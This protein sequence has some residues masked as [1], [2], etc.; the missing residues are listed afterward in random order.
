MDM[1]HLIEK[2]DKI[3]FAGQA[4]GQKP[5]DQVRGI[6]KATK[7]KSGEH[8][9]K[10]RL[11]G[12]SESKSLLQDLEK[13]IVEGAEER[14]LKEE[15]E[16]FSEQDVEEGIGRD[17][18]KLGGIA[19]VGIG[20]GLG[21]NYV[22]QQQPRVEVGG[23]KA[24]LIQHPG[25]GR[26]PDNA[27][28]LKGKDGKTYTVWASK[29]KGSTQYYATPSDNVKE[30][31]AEDAEPVDREFALVKKLGRL[32]QRIVQNPKL[33]K[34]YS[35]AI[36]NENIDWIVGLI[37][38]GTG[39]TSAEVT[40]LADLFGE[41]GGG[42][43]RIVD[44]AWAVKEG[45]WDKD[46]MN[47]YR[48]HRS[49]GVAEG[50]KSPMFK[51][52]QRA[53]RIRSL[54]NLIAIAREKDRPLRVQ[55]LELEL[56]KLQ[57]VSEGAQQLNIQQLATISDEAL[58]KAYG[59]GRSTPG[60]SFGWQANLKSAS[61]A[62]QM[63]D[64]GITDIEVISD[65]IHKGWNVTAQAFVKNP[66]QFSD[67]E[68]LKASGKLEAKLQQRAQLMKQNY[69]QLPEDEKE[70]DRV[71][72]RALLQA[73]KGQ[74]G[75]AEGL[76]DT[77]KKIEDTILKLE[78][79]LKFAKTP[80]QW[81]NIKNRIE[82]LQAG[83]NRSKQGVAEMDSQGHTGSRDRKK[84]SKYGSRDHYDLGGPES[85]G[86]PLTAK[87]MMDKAHKAMM[88]SM[89]NAEK[90]DKGWRNPNIDEGAGNIGNAIKSLYQKIYRA[91]DDEIEYF[92][93]DSPIFAQ[94]WDEY[95]GDL[96]SII[97][98][99][100][101]SELEVIKAELESYVDDANLTEAGVYNPPPGE[102][103]A[104]DSH[105][106]SP[107]GSVETNTER[108]PT[109]TVT[110]DIPLMIRLLE[111]A[112]E[113]AKD[114]MDLHTV[115]EKMI[116]L[117]KKGS[118]TMSDYDSIVKPAEI[119][120]DS[121]GSELGYKKLHP[122]AFQARQKYPLAKSDLEA[123]VMWIADRDGAEL[124][125][126]DQENDRE[127]AEIDQLDREE[128]GI[129]RKLKMLSAQIADLKSA[130]H[131]RAVKEAEAVATAG[132]PAGTATPGQP[133]DP[134]AQAQLKQQQSKLQQ[135]IANLKTAGVQ[136]DPAKAAQTLQKTDTGAPMTA[137]DKDTIA[138]M[139][140]ALG[141]VLANPSTATQL[142][143]LIKKAGG[144]V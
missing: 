135:N 40:K 132:A 49:Q 22:D 94:Y 106:P 77:Q 53:D 136:I 27:M 31:V 100:D 141:N 50:E 93:N 25:W 1:K 82:R 51:D 36:D 19:A 84:T 8:P 39:A 138:A 115:A 63:I 83:L 92:Y 78:Q 111:Y 74:Q 87:Q 95:E 70:K 6:E 139:A 97:A 99:V 86:R 30:G 89:S 15:F 128:D 71:V 35:E 9:F 120:E 5:G 122:I 112:R 38:D 18:A 28:T 67:T 10:G 133:A 56:K 104:T 58:D 131:S 60:N 119:S 7:K 137:T 107:I 26:V 109:D 11:V 20:A 12:A 42:L 68:K 88:K 16:N 143:T 52:A 96:D 144:G 13:Q 103:S 116:A 32:G 101:P 29:G 130:L 75:V 57:G 134:A 17:M 76:S 113:D 43:G 127:D 105:S 126:L 4:V 102:A 114:D 61:Y 44:F 33:W 117:G 3:E 45:T 72:A 142:N 37:Q 73:I 140:P 129:Q 64:K 121:E 48:D 14:R 98:E 90:V 125:R 23:Q 108:N 85:T 69:A 118:L 81:D 55:E 54:K 123:L 62:K 66:D 59:Y 65:A 47:P 124:S 80:E 21:A 24:Y 79:R 46:F 110:L 34:K 41:I 91:G 2:M